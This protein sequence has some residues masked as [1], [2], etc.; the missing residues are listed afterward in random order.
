MQKQ[1][2]A[3]LL[4]CHNRKSKTLDCLSSL[5]RATI[6][7]EYLIDVFLTDDGSTDGT[8]DAVEEQFPQVRVIR[9]DGTLFWA[10]GM[11]LAWETALQRK[12]Y[13]A[14]LLIN[15]DVE[16]Y[17]DFFLNLLKAENY[18]LA[19]TGKKGIYSG[20]TINEKTGSV[21]YGGSRVKD[22]KFL[23]R[24]QMLEPQE[25]P[26]Q[27]EMTNANV[28]WVSKEVVNEI[29]IFDKRFTHGIAD[30]DYS[31]QANKYKIPVLL[32]P[33]VCGICPD[34][35]GKNWR[36]SHYSLK[37]RISYL[38]SPKG[39]AYEEYMYYIRK[40]FPMFLPYSFAMLWTKTLFPFIWDRFKK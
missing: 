22:N 30:Y 38:K 3:V 21:T 19:E 25:E 17:P 40:H 36:D 16:L 27:C 7:T 13:D 18:S 26:Q 28:L 9:G 37:E 34:D 14:Y 2:I 6:P 35:H 29:G 20:A 12:L 24:M 39:L 33:N 5:F 11:R 1:N 15:D 32:A 23:I 10:G 4:T 31:L 8:G